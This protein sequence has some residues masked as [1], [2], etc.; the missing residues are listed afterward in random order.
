MLSASPEIIGR[1]SVRD[2]EDGDGGIILD[3]VDAVRAVG[4]VF[5]SMST[6]RFEER[7]TTTVNRMLQIV[8]SETLSHQIS[9]S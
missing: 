3:G 4:V 5:T 7:F 6:E 2:Q 8:K 1:V 9:I